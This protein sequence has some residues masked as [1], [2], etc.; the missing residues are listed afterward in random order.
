MTEG[1]WQPSQVLL[2]DGRTAIVGGRTGDQSPPGTASSGNDR[3]ETFSASKANG[4]VGR[5]AAAGQGA[6]FLTSLNP[7]L[8]ALPDDRMLMFGPGFWETSRYELP[9][10]GT[11]TRYLRR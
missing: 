5:F 1:R 3:A 8:F 10:G 7:H 4:G 11:A 9:S 6:E 2:S